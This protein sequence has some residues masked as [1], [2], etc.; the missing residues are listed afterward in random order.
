MGGPAG[1]ACPVLTSTVAG[2]LG[3][4]HRTAAIETFTASSFDRHPTDLAGLRGARLLSF[5]GRMQVIVPF[6][7]FVE[8][9]FPVLGFRLA[10]V[11]FSNGTPSHSATI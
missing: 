10:F 1:T 4:Y 3:E 6:E 7:G 9:K 2:I 8:V 11:P 5:R